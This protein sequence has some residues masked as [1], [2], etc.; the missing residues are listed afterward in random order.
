MQ[1]FDL[2]YVGKFSYQD[3]QEMTPHERKTFY[4]LLYKRK[5]EEKE[6]IDQ[7]RREAELKAKYGKG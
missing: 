4:H 2:V 5:K 3:T 7:A 6:A 1:Q